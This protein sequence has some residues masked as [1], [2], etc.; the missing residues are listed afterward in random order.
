MLYQLEMLDG[1]QASVYSDAEAAELR[2]LERRLYGVFERRGPAAMLFRIARIDGAPERSLRLPASWMLTA[3]FIAE[4][5]DRVVGAIRFM[6]RTAAGTS[7]DEFF[8]FRP[9]LPAGARDISSSM[10][11]LERAHRGFPRLLFAIS[12]MGY[13]WAIER[14]GTHVLGPANP[15]RRDAMLRHGYRIVAPQFQHQAKG[16][17]VLPMILDRAPVLRRG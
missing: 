6:E 3:N 10:L 13:Y 7:A 5:G 11:V 15:A 1:P 9:Y 16:L 12:G 8:D 14:G 17:P 2:S 4:V